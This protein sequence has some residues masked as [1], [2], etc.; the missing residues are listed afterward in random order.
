MV[1]L[2]RAV[3]ISMCDGPAAGLA[4]VEDLFGQPGLADYAPA[5]AALAELYRRLGRVADARGAFATALRLTKQE[6]TQRHLR[7]Q[8]D[9]LAGG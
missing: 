1:A 2:N 6:A 8:F 3:A 4:L 7:R 5:Y 9:A